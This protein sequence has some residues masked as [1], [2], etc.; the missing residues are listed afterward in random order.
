LAGG[1]KM[2]RPVT[3]GSILTWNDVAFDPSNPAT[4]LRHEMEKSLH[5]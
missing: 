1:I 3:E 5:P 2:V 4:K